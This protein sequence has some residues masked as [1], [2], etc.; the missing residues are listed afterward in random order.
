MQK[1]VT[2]VGITIHRKPDKSEHLK[3]RTPANPHT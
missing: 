3:I 1:V 2:V